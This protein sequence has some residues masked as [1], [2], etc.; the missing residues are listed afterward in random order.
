MASNMLDRAM[1]A[2]AGTDALVRPFAQ[3]IMSG[4]TS[5][6]VVAKAQ[7]S[8]PKPVITSSKISKTLCFVQMSRMRCRYRSGG[9]STP[10]LPA[11]GS[12]IYRGTWIK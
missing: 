12:I 11:T 10:V 2:P 4:V 5:K 9:G 7:P 8:L 6:R 3:V 1:T